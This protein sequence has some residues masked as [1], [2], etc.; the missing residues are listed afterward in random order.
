MKKRLFA[1]IYC[2]FMII[3]MVMLSGCSD[4]WFKDE[5]SKSPDYH[6]YEN[7]E[8]SASF[9]LEFRNFTED[10]EIESWDVYPHSKIDGELIY[11]WEIPMYGNTVY[12]SIKK[13]FEWQNGQ[14]YVSFGSA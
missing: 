1:L 11:S 10:Q 13:F 14:Y 5:Q 9:I 12:E 7:E 8:K 4:L 3:C 2:I 6:R